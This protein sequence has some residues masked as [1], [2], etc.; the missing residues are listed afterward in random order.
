LLTIS[1]TFFLQKKKVTK[2]KMIESPLL[3]GEGARSGERLILLILTQELM[4][5]RKIS[6]LYSEIRMK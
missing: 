6:S 3:S 4:I 2:E 1:V 5:Y